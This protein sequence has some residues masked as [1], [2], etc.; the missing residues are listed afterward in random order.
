MPLNAELQ[1]LTLPDGT[2]FPGT[3]QGLLNLI[4]QYAAI[5]GLADFSGVNFGDTEP[6]PE[7]RDRPWFKTDS[8]GNPIGWYSWNGAA[9]A[10]TPVTPQSGT[11]ADRPAPAILGQVYY[12]TDLST[13]LI[14]NGGGWVTAAGSIGDIKEVRGT[15]LAAVLTQNPGWEQDTTTIGKVIIGAAADGS[16][17]ETA[18]GADAVTILIENLPNDTIK[19]QSGVG[20]NDGS[21]QNGPQAPG[22]FPLVTAL[23][24]SATT[25]TGPINPDTQVDLDVRQ[26]SFAYFRLVKTS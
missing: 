23:G 12:D 21:F 8:A 5:T 26:A 19:M 3:M 4:C 10:P 6:T 7:E 18:I 22:K 2:E 15:T 1:P 20:V 9:W 17:A 24:A 14:Y 25:T 13:L 11:T 16:D